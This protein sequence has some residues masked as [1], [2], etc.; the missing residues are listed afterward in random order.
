M[1]KK[2]LY[3][4]ITFA[5][6]LAALYLWRYKQV[7][8]FK[9]R[10]PSSASK[11]VNVNLR[12]IEN[13]LLFDFLA[14]PI[15]YL[16][17]HKEK[18]SIKE[19]KTSLLKAISIPKNIVFYTNSAKLQ[20]NWFS[21]LISV[22]DD[23]E[24]SKYLIKESFNK[25]SE[26]STIFYTKAN[27]VLAIKDEQLIIGLKADNKV[28]INSLLISLFENNDFLSEDAALLKPLVNNKSDIS[29]TS[30][31][32]NFEANFKNGTFE[33]QGILSSDLFISD[34]NQTN[35]EKGVISFSGKFNK[36]NEVFE[37]FLY[38]KKDKFNEITHLSL[39]SIITKWNGKLNMNITAIEHKTDTIVSYEYDDD[40]NKVEIKSTQEKKIPTLGLMLGQENRSSLSDYFY[41]KN[42][43]QIIESDTIFTTIPIFKFLATNT[44]DKLL[45]NVNKK[46]EQGQ[47]SSIASRL[48][49]YFNAEKYVENPLDI[50]LNKDQKKF[51]KL[52]KTT[53]ISW[54]D[55]NQFS[56]KIDLKNTKRNFL[57]QL[58]KQ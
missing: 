56:L 53:K 50:P 10:V 39:D 8:V 45:L 13:H 54:E 20:N 27:F 44:K 18:D 25:S 12:Q 37:Q 30:A 15:T 43:I 31:D 29:F 40:F 51:L 57:G 49:F 1:R 46:G 6:V 26:N 36:E 17:P 5:V 4:F 58:V 21:S 11:V 14:N 7:Q 52:I 2:L 35:N 22:K 19:P 16:K 48:N 23:D 41:S 55:D 33:L 32:N 38:N 9:N 42:A 28:N 34:T 24:L 47:S 3:F